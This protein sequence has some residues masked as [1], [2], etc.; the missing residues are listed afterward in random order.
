MQG[1]F[2]L[3]A[4]YA[5]KGD[6]LILHYGNAEKPR[7]MLIDGGHNG[8][9]SEFL[10][11][12][13]EE[14]RQRW[15]SR[16]TE[17]KKLPFEMIMVSHADADHLQGI[18]DL[19]EHMRGDD[20]GRPPA[21]IQTDRL[22]FNGF[23]DVIANDSDS[24]RAVTASLAQT[25][26]FDEPDAMAIPAEMRADRDT[27]AVVAST[28][29]GRNLLSTAERL[30]IRSNPEFEGG[31]V[32]RGDGIPSKWSQ[33]EG[34]EFHL[35]GPD[36]KRIKSFRRKW[37]RDLTKILADERESAESASFKDSS[38]FNLASIMLLAI[39]GEHRMLLTGD[40]RGDHLILGLEE[41][42]F[43]D[44]EGKIHLDLFKLPHHGSDRN[45]KVDTFKCITADHY[46]ISANGEHGN[47]E[48]KTL[49]MLVEGRA[50]TTDT[51][52]K[53]HL[54]FP[55]EAHLLISDAQADKKKKLRKQKDALE[56]V[57]DWIKTRR[58]PNCEVVY[59]DRERR[60]LV[61]DLGDE[62]VF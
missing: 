53:I 22:W 19:T 46:L 20:L 27:R 5:K 35:L 58:P 38:V 1:F 30:E 42:G 44:A 33:G 59:R 4:V 14:L 50:A 9:Y 31:V 18:L 40:A 34:M 57:D 49:D 60:S 48:P 52:F 45:V 25:A 11:P 37:K 2:S 28:R 13:L 51:D 36:E 12:H 26:S 39:R 32:M 47:P 55:E 7:W 41:E 62:K 6:A 29:Q 3:E 43:L 24:G 54:T 61:V 56:A 21:P 15:P 17:K 10:Q 8:V 23:D 16:W